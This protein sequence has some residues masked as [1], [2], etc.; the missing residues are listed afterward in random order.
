MNRPLLPPALAF[1]AGILANEFLRHPPGFWLAFLAIIFGLALIPG[2]MAIAALWTGWILA[3]ALNHAIHNT[4][5]SPQDLRRATDTEARLV[6]L[7]GRIAETPSLRLKE[8]RRRWTSR[9]LASL[10]VASWREPGG[11]WSPATGT[12]MTSTRGTLPPEYFRGRYARVT[13]VLQLPPGPAAP[14]LFDYGRHLRQQDI[15]R[16]LDVSGPEDWIVEGEPNARAPLSEQFL[17]W[18]REALARGIPED[19]ATHLMWAMTLGWQTGLS[20]ETSTAFMESG[21]MHVFAISGLHIALIATLVCAALRAARIPRAATGLMVIPILWFYVAA[22]GW[23]SSAIRSAIMMTVITG[24]WILNRPADLL[25]SL[26]M[27]ALIILL[28]QPG[29]LL[30]AGFQLSFAVVAGLVLLVPVV[31]P[32]LFRAL[33]LRSDPMLPDAL[34]P[35]WSRRLDRP[36]RWLTSGLATGIAAF[37]SSLPFTVQ[38]FH[39]FSPVSVVANLVV[40]PLS[41]LAL[42]ANALSLAVSPVSKDLASIFNASAWVWMH[43]MV[44]LSRWFAGIPGGTWYVPSP[45]WPWWSVYLATLLA[46][47]KGGQPFRRHPRI[48]LAVAVSLALLAGFG[49]SRAFRRTSITVLSGGESILVDAPGRRQ[50]LLVNS[51]SETSGPGTVVPLLHTHGWNRIPTLM[52]AQAD[53][54]RNGYAPGM[55]RRFCPGKLVGGSPRLRSPAFREALREAEK[56]GIPFRRLHEGTT[57]SG[58]SVLW[59][60]LSDNARSSEEAAPVLSGSLDGFQILLLPSSDRKTQRALLETHAGSSRLQADLVIAGASRSPE[61]VLPELME[62]IQPRCLILPSAPGTTAPPIAPGYRRA[63]ED[64]GISVICTREHGT[65]T[66]ELAPGRM[67]LRGMDGIRKSWKG[68]SGPEGVN[69]FSVPIRLERFPSDDSSDTPDVFTPL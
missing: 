61:P 18:G 54:S 65:I 4:P 23:Q 10:D 8:R 15:Y 33:Q 12:V 50:D 55:V 40:V 60:R 47:A 34:R 43:G 63:M 6:E 14:G 13:G 64:A 46:L 30:Q 29:Q 20:G 38:T 59:P 22:T 3:G 11:V 53:A 57:V 2:R 39:L 45:P 56:L 36:I 16:T 21:T 25:N 9:T 35:R 19:E 1:G 42:S 41:S 44:A 27:S 69:S 52:L 5:L 26:A 28:W 62:A 66:L 58:W 68:S 17:P 51:G 37:F 48:T 24:T 32:L 49:V 67:E 7:Q 31:E